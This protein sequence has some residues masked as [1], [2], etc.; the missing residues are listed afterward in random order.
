[1]VRTLQLL[2]TLMLAAGIFSS[3]HCAEPVKVIL[4]E[5]MTRPLVQENSNWFLGHMRVLGYREGD[6]VELERLNGE[7]SIQKLDSLMESTL[8]EKRPDLVVTNATIASQV[9]RKHLENTDIPQ[10]FFGVTD[11]VGVG[12]ITSVG[13]PTHS[14]ISGI[15]HSPPVD[16]VLEFVS[17]FLRNNAVS[18]PVR[19]GFIHSNYPSSNKDIAHLIETVGAHK[20]IVFIPYKIPYL[21]G[22]S[23]KKEMTERAFAAAKELES[24]VDFWWQPRG[25]LGLDADFTKMLI[26]ETSV[27]IIHTA[28]ID[29][30][31][32]G[33][34]L[35]F[36]THPE[37]HGRETA[38]LADAILKGK[39][40]GDMPVFPT[41]KI[42]IAVNLT[43]ATKYKLVIP[44]EILK[45]AG[46][47]IF[48]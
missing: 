43:T 1:M 2:V 29:A 12:L 38:I 15:V 27:P 16:T 47:N 48:H 20:D 40:V 32:M 46:D 36:G 42:Q 13:I 19:I 7:G 21:K 18:K 17:S 14:N 6:N 37:A 5:S 9:A 24:E 30:V 35:N 45:I 44:S 10:L 26:E 33:G 31:R 11:P 25:P 39:Y 34:L 3:G 22:D 41:S 4:L 8:A 28:S 23:R